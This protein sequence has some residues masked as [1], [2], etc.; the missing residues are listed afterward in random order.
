[1][2]MPERRPNHISPAELQMLQ[3]VFDSACDRRDIE[4]AGRDGEDMA[5]T[6]VSLYENGLCEEHQLVARLL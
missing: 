6:I 1:M 3:R 2:K 4:K 5:A